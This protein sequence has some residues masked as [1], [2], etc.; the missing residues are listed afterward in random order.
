[1][2]NEEIII[3]I[4]PLGISHYEIQK[5]KKS[6]LL[7]F[8]IQYSKELSF[9]LYQQ[10]RDHLSNGEEEVWYLSYTGQGKT[11][12][13]GNQYSEDLMNDNRYRAVSILVPIGCP[14]CVI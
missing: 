11:I 7:L 5:K 3:D 4:N 14:S 1:M 6:Y 2:H 9:G 8:F 13:T 10:I 12:K